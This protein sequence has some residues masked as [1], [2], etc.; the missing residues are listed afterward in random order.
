[1]RRDLQSTYLT[2]AKVI[3]Q[4]LMVPSIE[5][6][7][8][9]ASNC[10]TFQCVD[11]KLRILASRSILSNT[12]SPIDEIILKRQ[13]GFWSAA[14]P[15]FQSRW[16]FLASLAKLKSEVDRISHEFKNNKLSAATIAQKYI[17]ATMPWCVI[18]TLH[19]NVERMYQALDINDKDK[20]LEKLFTDVREQYYKL[21]SQISE[22]FVVGLSEAK[23]QLPLFIKQRE[24]FSKRVKPALEEAKI[25]YIW[26]DALRYEMG[27]ELAASLRD[28]FEVTTEAAIASVPTITEIGMSSLLPITDQ[29]LSIVSIG[30]GKLALQIGDQVIKDRK[31]RIDFLKAQFPP[32]VIICAAK[33]EDLLP[34]PKKRLRDEIAEAK[35]VLL[36]SQEIDELCESDNVSLARRAMQ[37][38]LH[39]LK[40]AIKVLQDLGVTRFILAADHG[41]IFGEELSPDML[42]NS[43]GGDTKDLH[44]RVWLGNGGAV[45]NAVLRTNLKVFDYESDLEIAVPLSLG[46]FKVQ[47]G[48]K[49]YFHGGM[50]LQ[51]LLIP[52]IDLKPKKGQKR[53]A[54]DVTLQL[55]PGSKKITT[56]FF[57]V[58]ITG[59]VSTFMDVQPPVIRV[60]VRSGAKSISTPIS[61]SYGFEDATGEVRL[62]FEQQNPQ[63]IE[64]NTITLQIESVKEIKTVSLHLF[65]SN[66][67]ELSRLDDIEYA[68]SI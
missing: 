44:R 14:L 36:T 67:V 15:E 42:I 31:A 28:D 48:A 16:A 20:D 63:N 23:Y 50:S 35:I 49:N 22:A 18:D 57:S 40:R 6:D 7:L 37:D 47:G 51:E 11:D 19:R 12:G 41:H 4:Q 33:L 61:A 32:T 45:D 53:T 38:I 46:G 29:R 64:S 2:N 24:V 59:S 54:N 10:E 65:D 62:R 58:Q 17:D 26:V 43:P 39:E 8:E 27:I 52:V 9:I 13:Q 30:E 34:K 21:S 66:G 5:I 56:R 60:E 55:K 1:M 25:A 68:I 3:E